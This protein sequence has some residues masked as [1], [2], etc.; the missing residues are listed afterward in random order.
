VLSKKLGSGFPLPA[1]MVWNSEILRFGSPIAR[2]TRDRTRTS[3]Q[4]T[5]TD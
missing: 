4:V 2:R 5:L 1:S 3:T